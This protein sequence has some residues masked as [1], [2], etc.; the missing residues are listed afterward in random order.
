MPSRSA[1]GTLASFSGLNA[2]M[3]QTG[4][5]GCDPDHYSGPLPKV[6]R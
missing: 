5:A 1:A 2:M 4:D 6:R 3:E